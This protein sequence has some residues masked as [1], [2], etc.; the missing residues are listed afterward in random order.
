MKLEKIGYYRTPITD[1]KGNPYGEIR[2]E[3]HKDLS[4]INLQI[5]L[6][7]STLVNKEDVK[8][9]SNSF[10][11]QFQEEIKETNWKFILE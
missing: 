11:N 10:I 2:G 6:Y 4:Q 9:L 1:A 5:N 3:I 7:D 8:K